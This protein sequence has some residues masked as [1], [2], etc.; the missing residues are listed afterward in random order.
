M[1]AFLAAAGLSLSLLWTSGS[2]ADEFNRTFS[3]QLGASPLSIV[4]PNSYVEGDKTAEDVEDGLVAYYYSKN[5]LLDFDVYEF[6][7]E[8]PDT[9][10]AYLEEEA[11]SFHG[12]DFKVEDINGFTVASYHAVEEDAG[13]SYETLTY[14]LEADEEYLEVVFW[15]D[16]ENAEEL[17]VSFMGTLSKMDTKE[18]QIGE[19]SYFITVPSDYMEGTVPDDEEIEILAE[20]QIAYYYSKSA[21]LDFDLYVFSKEDV[22]D[23]LEAYLE[24]EAAEYESRN[25]RMEEINGIKVAAYE[26]L[27]MAMNTPI[28][29]VTYIMEDGD[30]YVEI[31]FWRYG[32]IAAKQAQSIIQT[33]TRK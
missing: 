7:K 30:N 2:A 29:T 22:A 31:V 32:V 26:A 27:E 21:A 16:G 4:V 9:I 11:A 33:L 23:T 15:L 17:A 19:T 8:G 13:V 10:E 18:V 6:E 1:T 28:S 12:T 3:L 5:L 24:E 25:L 14:G 20:D